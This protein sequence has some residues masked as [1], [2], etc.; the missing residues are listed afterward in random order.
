MSSLG[1]IMC[2]EDEPILLEDIADELEDAGYDTICASTGLEALKLMRKQKPDLILCD[3]MMPGLDGPSLLKKVREHKTGLDR[4][5]FVFLTARSSREDVIAGKMM[6][7]DDY[8]TK[9]VDFEMLLATVHAR[10]EEVKRLS[11]GMRQQLTA[12]YS[13]LQEKQDGSRPLR[14]SMIVDN[15]QSMRPIAAA[16]QDLGC[17]VRMLLDQH[18]ATQN[19]DLS[20]DD[21]VFLVYSQIVHLQLKDLIENGGNKPGKFVMLTPA[22]I[23]EELTAALR[24]SGISDCIGYPYKP[25][26]IFRFIMAKMKVK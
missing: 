12:I 15:P 18:I 11:E 5:P 3:M 16:M 26:E 1:T 4:I 6:G 25:A 23:S 22:S 17:E 20:K 24:E 14:V 19:I 9:P 13:E 21:A 10:L 2:V 7:A 8:L